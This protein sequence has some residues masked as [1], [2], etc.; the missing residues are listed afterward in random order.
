MDINILCIL[1]PNPETA[2]VIL[3][4]GLINCLSLNTTVTI[5]KNLALLWRTAK[6]RFRNA[7]I[8]IPIIN[9]SL[10]LAP[11]TRSLL[12]HLNTILANKYN[13][14]PEINPLLFQVTP[15]HVHWTPQTAEMIFLYW[16]TH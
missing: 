9:F 5:S 1:T 12:N 13:F 2:Q 7:T 6:T 15:D 14:S 10:H 11:N 16:K 8:H 3:S 4:V